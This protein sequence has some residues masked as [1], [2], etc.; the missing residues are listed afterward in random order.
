MHYWKAFHIV[1][2]GGFIG[3]CG[4]SSDG[5]STPIED[6]TQTAGDDKSG[7]DESS[8]GPGGESDSGMDEAGVTGTTGAMPT[9]GTTGPTT[10]EVDTSATETGATGAGAVATG[11]YRNLFA[12]AGYTQAEIDAKLQAAFE[13]LFYGDPETQALYYPVGENA[14]GPMAQIRDIASEDIRSEGISYGMMIAV[15]TDHKAEFD[16]LWNWANESMLIDDPSH[17][18]FG[19]FA[20]QVDFEGNIIDPMPAPD[21]EEY[22]ATALYFASGRWGNGTGIYDYHAQADALLDVIKNRQEITGTITA[23][24]NTYETT[25]TTLFNPE[26]F[27]VRFTPN[28]G[29]FTTNGDHTDPSYH[30]PAF[31]ELWALWG[32]EADRAFWAQAA[33][34]SR[35]FF[36]ATTHPTTGLAPDYAEFDGSPKAAS[37]DD[38]TVN[39]R[40]DAWRTAMNWSFDWAWF[41]ADPREQ[42]LSD[43]I[44]AFFRAQG[45]G[46][47]ANQFTL[48]GEPLS[49]DHSPGLVAMNATAALA[50]TEPANDFV[51][52]LWNVTVPSGQYRYYDGTLY[53]MALLHCAGQFQVYPPQ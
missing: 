47:Y 51:E 27:Q 45:I 32:P 17:P 40:F 12:E 33:A 24:G 50:T 2:L 19:Y 4:T 28:R 13:Q 30:L 43:R 42:E 16:A 25:G 7:D 52:A 36:V 15:Q 6:A 3:A 8:D 39:F 41:A 9:T 35:D 1:A 53:M 22:I 23:E 10:G 44:L 34:T 5:G 26:E 48:A 31:Y 49:S 38:G 18:A 14:N 21:G 20:W 29:N 37:W 11:V 46:T